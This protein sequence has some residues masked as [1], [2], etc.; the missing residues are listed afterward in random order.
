[1]E[2]RQIPLG[3]LMK[4]IDSA[5]RKRTD[6]A[7]QGNDLTFAQSHTLVAIAHWPEGT[8]S[9][10]E[11]ERQFRVA[12][13]TMAGIVARL[14]KKGLIETVPNETDRRI[15]RLRVTPAGEELL[16]RTREAAAESE[17]AVLSALS[18]SEQA[19][20]YD[21]LFKVH[22]SLCCEKGGSCLCP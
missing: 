15:K 17:R 21:L 3:A 13:S 20:L 10:K 7:V 4:H 1:M 6:I 22:Q 16:L 12:Q 2:Q 8:A 14:E 18:E 9:L 5:I 19:Q 11:L